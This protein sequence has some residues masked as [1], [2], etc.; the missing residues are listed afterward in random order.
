MN[1][2]ALKLKEY[3]SNEKLIKQIKVTAEQINDNYFK[4]NKNDEILNVI[5]VL[6]G[7]VLFYSE[8]VK[9][10]KMPINMHFVT[11]SSYGGK[12][13]TSG[14][15]KPMDVN[16]PDLKNKNILI[17]EDII[18]TGLTLSYFANYINNKFKPKY[19]KTVT[20]LDKKEC[21]KVNFST[22]FN[23]FEIENKFVVGFGMDYDEQY[24]NL[25]YIAYI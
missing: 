9:Y 2:N 24:R 21:R 18:D 11:L 22:D 6:K 25:D 3:I 7:A 10:L 23:C 15:V 14:N 13:E 20:L 5:C 12:T 17:V 19:L 8:I 16:L 4:S 1:K